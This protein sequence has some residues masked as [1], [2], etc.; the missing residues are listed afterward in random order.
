MAELDPTIS[1]RLQDFCA[2]G[3]RLA[4]DGK[5]KDAIAA[6]NQAWTLSPEPATEWEA[7]TWVLAAIADA[8][9]LGGF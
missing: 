2:E 7:S 5:Y 8:S 6:Y 1:K 3:D 9:F 4:A